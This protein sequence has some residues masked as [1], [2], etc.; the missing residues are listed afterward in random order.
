MNKI[1]NEKIFE[2]W[3]VF[4]KKLFQNNNLKNIF[5]EKLDELHDNDIDH[6]E[7]DR[8]A[9][10]NNVILS[11]VAVTNN[12]NIYIDAYVEKI[13]F[14]MGFYRGFVYN[15]E[16]IISPNIWFSFEYSDSF[17]IFCKK[18]NET[19]DHINKLNNYLTE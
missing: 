11:G 15:I 10:I 3:E 18:R 19:I 13:I 8:H 4:N 12:Q 9:W 6:N 16:D 14:E 2:G 1:T 17:D 7:L 5:L